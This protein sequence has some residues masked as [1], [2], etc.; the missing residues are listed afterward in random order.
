M[1]ESTLKIILIPSIITLAVT[2]LR[3]TGELQGWSRVW[4]NPTAGGGLAPIGIVWLVFVFGAWFAVK[5]A[6]DGDMPASAGRTIGL[7]FL[8]FV[9]FDWPERCRRRAEAPLLWPP[10]GC[11][12][13]EHC[14]GVDSLPLLALSVSRTSSLRDCG[15]HP[16]DR[17]HVVGNGRQLGDAL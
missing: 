2:L 17:H 9:L 10:A 16:G 11:G 7:A 6:R 1:K 3:L 4:F 15:T 14:Y 8:S 5:L 13:G 12:C